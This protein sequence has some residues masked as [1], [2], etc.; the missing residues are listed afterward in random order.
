[1]AQQHRENNMDD[2]EV[3][4]LYGTPE[5]SVVTLTKDKC[6]HA[7]VMRS[8]TDALCEKCL[9]GLILTPHLKVDN[10]KIVLAS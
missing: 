2:K 8:A 6:D 5:T 10:G 1:M 7:F 4:Q 3:E 9:T